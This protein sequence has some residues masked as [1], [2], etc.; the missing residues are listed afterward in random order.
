M[1]GYA[2]SICACPE[3]PY[4]G[5]RKAGTP[6]C[7]ERCGFMTQEQYEALV[8]GRRNIAQ[9]VTLT[10]L[11]WNVRKRL[12]HMAQEDWRG[13]KP[14]HI[15]EAQALVALINTVI[16]SEPNRRRAADE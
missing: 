6:C 9:E 11:L 14:S 15:T 8:G 12:Q 10:V 3:G 4:L 1:S 16:P 13:P 7:C 2:V 5:A